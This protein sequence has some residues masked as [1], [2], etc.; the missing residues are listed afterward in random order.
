MANPAK[1]DRGINIR[2]PQILIVELVFSFMIFF[3]CC[4]HDTRRALN[5]YNNVS[6]EDED[7]EI[8]RLRLGYMVGLLYEV[9]LPILGICVFKDHSGL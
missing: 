6:D 3:W 8:Y 1:C 7:V 2:L 4:R 5:I 9:L